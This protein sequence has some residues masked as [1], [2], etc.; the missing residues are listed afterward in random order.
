VAS[1]RA[2]GGPTQKTLEPLKRVARDGFETRIRLEHRPDR[3][4]VEALDSHGRT[5]ARSGGVRT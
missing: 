5:L 2:Y 3:V 1:W 4:A